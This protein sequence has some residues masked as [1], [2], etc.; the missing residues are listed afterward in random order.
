MAVLALLATSRVAL[1]GF[2]A[3]QLEAPGS[4]SL[5]S[6]PVPVSGLKWGGVGA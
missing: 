1:A 2:R 3:G 4:G 6:W 5:P